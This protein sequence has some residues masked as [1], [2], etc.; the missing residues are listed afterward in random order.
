M[1]SENSSMEIM[2][3]RREVSDGKLLLVYSFL[4]GVKLFG[5]KNGMGRM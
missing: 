2:F 1:A 5:Q 3:I 4:F